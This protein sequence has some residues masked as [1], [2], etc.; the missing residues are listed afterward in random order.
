MAIFGQNP[1]LTP[2]KKCQFFDFL[3]LSLRKFFFSFQ[4]I[5]KD[6]FLA[7][8]AKIEKLEKRPFLDQNHGLTPLE[9]CQFFNFLKILFLQPRKAFFLVQ[10]M[11]KDIFVAYIAQKEKLEKRPFIYQDHGLTP[12]EKCEYFDVLKYLFLWLRKVFFRSRIS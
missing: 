12:L 4:N 5:V 11:V 1:G 8:I 6:I 3:F 7:Y 9:K 2:L 10:N